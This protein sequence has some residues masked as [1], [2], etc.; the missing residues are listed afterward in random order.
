M[1]DTAVR[2]IALTGYFLLNSSRG[3]RIG[4]GGKAWALFRDFSRI[5]IEQLTFR[6]LW[7]DACQFVAC[8]ATVWCEWF[9]AV[10]S[11][12]GGWREWGVHRQPE[13]ITVGRCRYRAGRSGNRLFAGYSGGL[14]KT[15]QR[16]MTSSDA[17]HIFVCTSGDMGRTAELE[18]H[19]QLLGRLHRV[20]RCCTVTCVLINSLQWIQALFFRIVSH[21]KLRVMFPWHAKVKL[22]NL[23]AVQFL[24][25]VS[26]RLG[27]FAPG[28]WFSFSRT[29]H[30]TSVEVP[31]FQQALGFPGQSGI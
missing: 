20:T 4:I 12:C 2:I 11:G 21:P 29:R 15:R 1:E 30:P 26:R 14:F 23:G 18:G 28:A 31:L 8:R 25:L 17:N 24:P 9:G 6:D 13:R 5:A 7:C 22:G 10:R 3:C 19:R 27:Y 16:C